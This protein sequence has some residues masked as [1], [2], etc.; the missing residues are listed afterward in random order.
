MKKITGMLRRNLAW[1]MSVMLVLGGSARQM[2]AVAAE[3]SDI[4][5]DSGASAGRATATNA[6]AVS[7]VEMIEDDL[8]TN[9][10]AVLRSLMAAGDIWTDW[11]GMD[12]SFLDGN[13]GRGTECQ[14]FQI[15]TR[16]QLMALS[17]L[18]SRGM[19][20]HEGEL[21]SDAWAGDYEGAYF[22]LMSDINLQGMNWI[23]IGFY[24][25]M[26]ELDGPVPHPFRGHFDGNGYTISNFI[27]SN[28]AWHNAG[29]F[30]AIEDSSI[31][32]LNIS[33]SNTLTAG[34]QAGILAGYAAGEISI[35]NCSVKGNVRA[36]GIAGGL[37]G[38]L[39]GAPTQGAVV[40][41]CS[42]NVTIDS[43]ASDSGRQIC[44]GGIAGQADDAVIVDC[45]VE[46]ANNSGARIQGK[47]YVGG[48]T[49]WQNN[50]DIYNVFV[51]SGTIGGN[52]AT[53][54][55]GI[56][57]YYTAGDIKVA[58]MQASIGSSGLGNSAHEG[59][60]IGDKGS[61]CHFTFGTAAE[62]DMT[63]LF[64]NTEAKVN[65]GICGS[66]VADDNTYTYDAHIGFWHAGDL[67]FT[68][69]QGN[70]T[71]VFTDKYFYEELELGILT[72]MDNEI[73]GAEVD[74][75]L[76]HVAPD[77]TGRP[78]R[79]Y[80]ISIPQI[81]TVANGTH[82]YDVAALTV[83]GSGAYYKPLDKQNRGAVA[84]GTAV[85]IATA[86]KNTVT[87]KYQ[88]EGSPYYWKNGI[89]TDA[90]YV[91]GGQYRFLMPANDTEVTAT[92]KRV[93]ADIRVEPV[94][95]AFRV[96]QTRTGNRKSPTLTTVVTGSNGTE[97][98]RYVNGT[99]DSAE[100]QPVYIQKTVDTN[101]DVAD[102]RVQWSVDSP[103]LI[104]LL[105]NDDLDA[106]GY[107]DK[108]ASIQVKLDSAF[109]SDIIREAEAKQ[110]ESN[111]RYAIPS[112][113]YGA[114]HEKG[115]V[116]ILTAATRNSESFEGKPCTAQ[117]RIEVTFQIL[118]QT[119]VDIEGVGLNHS[120]MEFIVTRT[121]KGSAKAPTETISVTAPKILEASFQPSFFSKKEVS[122]QVEDSSVISLVLDE[123][124]SQYATVSAVSNAGWI[125]DIITSD[126]EKKAAN[127]SVKVD[128]NGERQTRIIVKADDRNGNSRQ[129]F[130]TVKVRFETIDS[131]GTSGSSGGGG[132]G[133]SSSSGSRAVGGAGASGL[134]EAP[135]GAVTGTW[136]QT[137]DGN[138]TF[139]SQSHNYAKEWAYIYNPYAASGQPSADWFCFGPDGL[140]LTGWYTDIDGHIY[141]LNPRSD[142]TQGSMLTGWQWVDE[143]FYY[144]NTS[145]NETY[146]KGALL[147]NTITRTNAG[148]RDYRARRD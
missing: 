126:Q 58:R 51:S 94:T 115:G 43:P 57:G 3:N 86:P 27:I 131:T 107:T 72:I 25:N 105:D 143:R 48:I 147:K 35:R 106:L 67:Y 138:W 16:T 77:S 110:A 92:Y 64:T 22:E 88:M 10:N 135:A 133:G 116:A 56:T 53:A 42:V 113:I 31:V 52:G 89:W 29:L 36:R 50:T 119:Y 124:S 73:N 69:K 137:A 101:N 140:M 49:G 121:L 59:V 7:G 9:A 132:G 90:S 33:I 109:F 46:T 146:P 87:E 5:A 13:H 128:G 14:P 44:V 76:N 80:L 122:W 136:S 65:A 120:E 75:A 134:S 130:C 112:T 104:R 61:G 55:G 1:L 45:E 30:G 93:A 103:G 32:N 118:D 70:N 63:Y 21:E 141:Y 20:I 100:V 114:G 6:D 68:L 4:A 12:F 40:E 23:P 47:G 37:V 54:I 8:A 26:A 129:A 15:S 148:G 34:N 24:Q 60:F 84:A 17:W 91:A 2:E 85:I 102:S 66:D 145:T 125:R 83:T 28:N 41:D 98:A 97:I 127:A 81:D 123:D 95:A 117:C 99:L 78:A 96:V 144:F 18:A 111:Y 82:F 142:N 11:T 71:K 39:K 19:N 62:D 139:A 79:G 108:S 74:Y 38:Y